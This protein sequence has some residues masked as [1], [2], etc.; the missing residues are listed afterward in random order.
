[1]PPALDKYQENST[2]FKKSSAIYY[3]IPKK[4][5][6]FAVSNVDTS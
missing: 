3:R 6:T 4:I 2:F 5:N 1:M